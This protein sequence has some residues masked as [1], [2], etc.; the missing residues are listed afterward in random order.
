MK[1][2]YR[3]SREGNLKRGAIFDIT[4]QV[5]GGMIRVNIGLDPIKAYAD[6]D[7]VESLMEDWNFGQYSPPIDGLRVG[8]G[9]AKAIE[10]GI[11][12]NIDLDTIH[13]RKEMG[14]ILDQPPSPT[15]EEYRQGRYLTEFMKA[16]TYPGSSVPISRNTERK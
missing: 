7:T 8:A 13:L 15:A 16:V 14:E 1:A 2:M 10:S 9:V 5:L 4:T 6:Y 3:G 11:K 12:A